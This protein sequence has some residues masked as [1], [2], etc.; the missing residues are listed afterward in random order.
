[1]VQEDTM[2]VGPVAP[3]DHRTERVDTLIHHMGG[4]P[5]LY[6]HSSKGGSRWDSQGM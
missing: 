2:E 4:F 6:I 5:D 1:V 3:V